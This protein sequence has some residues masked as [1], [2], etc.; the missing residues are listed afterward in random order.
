MARIERVEP[1]HAK[2]TVIEPA[3]GGHRGRV[4]ESTIDRQPSART[5]VRT[6]H[7]RPGPHTTHDRPSL[8]ARVQPLADAW[9]P[10]QRR[11]RV[12]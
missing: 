1:A 6:T 10:S 5:P 8:R 7:D 4:S 12:S 9:R 11:G 2:A 3:P